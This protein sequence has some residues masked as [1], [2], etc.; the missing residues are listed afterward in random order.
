MVCRRLMRSGYESVI[1][2]AWG[3]RPIFGDGATTTTTALRATVADGDAPE[4]TTIGA[5]APRR[6]RRLGRLQPPL[7]RCMRHLLR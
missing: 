6:T 1:S 4:A 2:A 3:V 5:P 7:L